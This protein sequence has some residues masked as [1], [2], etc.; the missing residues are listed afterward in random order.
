MYPPA[1]PN[2]KKCN[3]L[4]S[5]WPGP[6]EMRLSWLPPAH[7]RGAGGLQVDDLFQSVVKITT[8]M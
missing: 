4:C 3:W 8:E 1:L 5:K 2:A 6:P 7:K